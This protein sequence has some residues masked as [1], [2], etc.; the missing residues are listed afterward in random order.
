MNRCSG[1]THTTHSGSGYN[2][3]EPKRKRVEK[4]SRVCTH[5]DEGS[6]I[7]NTPK[8]FKSV[9]P[10]PMSGGVYE[11]FSR[12]MPGVSLR[13][14]HAVQRGAVVQPC[15]PR[16]ASLGCWFG[17]LQHLI[18]CSPAVT[19]LLDL[20]TCVYQGEARREGQ[21]VREGGG[22]ISKSVSP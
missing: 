2:L 22:G 12:K 7:G 17:G 5:A 8:D 11:P 20:Y 3:S 16:G 14:G 6:M 9:L 4:R 19:R 18:T 21:L 13:R 10:V 1:Q 15:P